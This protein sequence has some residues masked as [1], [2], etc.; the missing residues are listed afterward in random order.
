METKP[1]TTEQRIVWRIQDHFRGVVAG[2]ARKSD[3]EKRVKIDYE[4]FLHTLQDNII[5][6][7]RT[8]LYENPQQNSIEKSLQ[9]S[10]S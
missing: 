10:E 9:K 7:I 2:C 6:I 1:Q 4:G 3:S 8:E 5:D